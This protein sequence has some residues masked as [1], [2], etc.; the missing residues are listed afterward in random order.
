MVDL[1]TAGSV[2]AGQTE[3]TCAP[4]RLFADLV[5]QSFLCARRYCLDSI[6]SIVGVMADSG[7]PCFQYRDDCVEQLK[8]RFFPHASA[9][10]AARLMRALVADACR[11]WTTVAYDGVQK[12]QNNIYSDCWK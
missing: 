2:G 10:E 4:F 3:L 5:V 11:K 8:G 6:L 9:N 12:L 7:L 1:I